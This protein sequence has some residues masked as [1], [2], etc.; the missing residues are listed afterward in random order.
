MRWLEISVETISEATEL[1]SQALCDAGANGT[2]V[3]DPAD[4]DRYQK[5]DNSWDY[6]DPAIFEKMTGV[7]VR[8]YLS[9]EIDP[10]KSVEH[11]TLALN[12]MQRNG[13]ELGSMKITTR[14]VDDA[15]WENEWK[16]YYK[17][18]RIGRHIVIKPSWEDF[19]AEASDQVIELDPGMA[20]GTGS[21]ET[22]R[23][24]VK[25]LEEY[26]Q[27]DH[28][29]LDIGCGSG[30]LSLAAAKLGAKRVTAV[31]LDP[32][33]VKVTRENVERNGQEAVIEAKTGNLL[34]VVQGRANVVVAN[35]IADVII[36]LSKSVGQFLV[37]GGLFI[38]SGIIRDRCEEVC[39]AIRSQGM[40]IERVLTDGE[41][42]AIAARLGA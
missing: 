39:Q 28:T 11:I 9:E 21:H 15:D 34:D 42:N 27:I 25:L 22:T 38:A 36:I 5:P 6:I 13:A 10:L 16:K 17:P 2:V 7:F 33:C 23:M 3:E 35:I 1:V 26:L 30:I 24:C 20:F 19:D 32:V 41:W 37:D 8:A 12:R 31:D 4:L 40:V 18:F 29:V 14:W